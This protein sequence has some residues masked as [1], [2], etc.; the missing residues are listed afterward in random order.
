VIR[1]KMAFALSCVGAMRYFRRNE[2]VASASTST[3]SGTQL[4]L[5]GVRGRESGCGA[6]R[7]RRLDVGA[8]VVDFWK[9]DESAYI[10]A[11]IPGALSLP[12]GLPV[13]YPGKT[14]MTAMKGL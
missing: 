14:I 7:V 2:A 10:L 4:R 11:E 9:Q 1:L 13:V 8:S 5:P 12:G 6:L 3:G